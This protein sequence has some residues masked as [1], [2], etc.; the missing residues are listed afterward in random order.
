MPGWDDTPPKK[1]GVCNTSDMNIF[2]NNITTRVTTGPSQT[3]MM[4]QW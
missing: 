2:I 1:A 3:G 4:V